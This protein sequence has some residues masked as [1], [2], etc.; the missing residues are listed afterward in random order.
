MTAPAPTVDHWVDDFSRVCNQDEEL[1]N[2]GTFYSC[3]YLLDMQQR[4]FQV[5]MHRGH[6]EDVRIDPGPLDARYQFLLRASADTWREFG[7][8]EPRA[9]CHGIWAATFREDMRMEGDLLVLMQNLRCF[10]RQMELLR[11]TGVPV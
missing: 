7:K 10:T 5:A 11:V 6:V 1:R 2:H 4:S 8:K 9:M 3:S